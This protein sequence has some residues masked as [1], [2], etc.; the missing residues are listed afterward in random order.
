VFPLI[1]GDAAAVAE[2]GTNIPA[3]TADHAMIA[4]RDLSR[5]GVEPARIRFG[6]AISTPVIRCTHDLPIL[7]LRHTTSS[8]GPFSGNLIN[9]LGHDVLVW[10]GRITG[11]SWR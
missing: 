2:L 3:T 9:S 1:P 7:S 6:A 5:S 8:S 4:A 10:A 11:E